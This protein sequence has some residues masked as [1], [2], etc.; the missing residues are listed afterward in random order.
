MAGPIPTRTLGSERLRVGAVGYGAMSF[1]DVYG[2]SGYDKDASARVILNRAAALGVTLIDTA[3][4][5][6]PSEEILG[7]AL[8][9]H[10]GDF[11]VATKF[12]SGCLRRRTWRRR[13]MGRVPTCASSSISRCV[14]WH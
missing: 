2:Q 8:A 9:G 3:D 7:R 1:A 10:R 5:Y 13:S 6:G 4:V 14:A 11:V 12:A